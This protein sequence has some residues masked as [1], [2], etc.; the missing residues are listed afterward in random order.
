M[1]F[2]I[3]IKENSLFSI[4]AANFHG[5]FMNPNVDSY[6]LIATML[7]VSLTVLN[8]CDQL[9][10]GPSFSREKEYNQAKQQ[11]KSR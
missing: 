7:S 4:K 5:K 10:G 6:I 2:I 3:D 8:D 11:Q 1:L 9:H